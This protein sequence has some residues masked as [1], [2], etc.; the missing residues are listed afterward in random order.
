M[1]VHTEPSWHLSLGS[2]SY[3]QVDFVL[4]TVVMLF[5]LSNLLS[6]L[7][8]SGLALVVGLVLY[9]SSINDEVLNRTKN[10]ETYFSY[11]YGW[12]FAFAAIS[13]LLTKVTYF[14]SYVTLIIMYGDVVAL[15]LHDLFSITV[16]IA[17]RPVVAMWNYKYN[18]RVLFSVVFNNFVACDFF[19]K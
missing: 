10:S 16:Y 5:L 12:S 1:F 19:A 4:F 8:V 6:L 14:H 7:V 17:C 3:S 11:K 18:E 15:L 13:F 2:S 9:I